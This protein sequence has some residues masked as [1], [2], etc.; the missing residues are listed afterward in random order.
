[1][2][3]LEELFEVP[4]IESYGMTEAAHQM[5]SN[6]LPPGQRK[7]G[8][9]GLAAGPE[10]SVMDGA[11]NLL[12]PGEI[13]EI[14]IRG[15]NVTSGYINSVES[16]TENFAQGWFRTGDQGYLDEDGYLFISGRLKEIINRG[17][18]KISPRE[19]DEALLEHPDIS[20][21]IAFAVPHSTLGEDIAAAVVAREKNQITEA[22]IRKYLGSRLAAYKIP[23]RILFVDD[24]P[25]GAT[26]KTQR[27][28][29][30]EKFADRLKGQYV[31]LQKEREAA[32]AQI[33]V[34]VLGV[35]QV[36]ATDNF[37]ALGGDSLRATQ[38]IARIRARFDVNLSIGTIFWQS[39]VRE[40]AQEIRRVTAVTDEDSATPRGTST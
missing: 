31:A 40:L 22:A 27:I 37:F 9:V 12:S 6:P 3:G 16:S 15:A 5:A 4:V 30:A 26:G 20:Q 7:V 1:M 13:G 18:E 10:V 28:G 38:V 21:A 25:K 11:G 8:S 23:S 24:L 17:G 35:E 39:T 19:V 33:Y 14:V 34:E 29:L 32:V 2:Q 36:G